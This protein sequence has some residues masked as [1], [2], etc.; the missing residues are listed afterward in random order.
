MI[1]T[2]LSSLLKHFHFVHL[3]ELEMCSFEQ[4]PVV[5]LQ[6]WPCQY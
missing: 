2:F 1:E 6:I 3:Q 4:Q 5:D